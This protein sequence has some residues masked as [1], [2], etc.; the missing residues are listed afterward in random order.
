[1]TSNKKKLYTTNKFGYTY[2]S[3]DIHHNSQYFRANFPKLC[4]NQDNDAKLPNAVVLSKS[5]AN[6]NNKTLNRLWISHPIRKIEISGG[7]I[8]VDAN[9]A[10]PSSSAHLIVSFKIAGLSENM[11]TTAT[12]S[13]DV[14]A[15]YACINR[16][17]NFPNN[18]KKTEVSGPVEASV[19]FTSG[20]K[21]QV[22]RILTIYL[23]A[24]TLE[25]PLGQEMVLVS[26]SYTN[27]QVSEPH[28]GTVS[29]EGIFERINFE[30]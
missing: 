21:E 4:D 9:V 7:A 15:V 13:A 2:Q 3:D 29:I 30:I 26:A 22:T 19:R 12:A 28:A 5:I 1:M 24:I 27:V 16:S 14:T 6:E 23:P 18:L 20:K 17:G 11:T 8:L 10:G 25:C